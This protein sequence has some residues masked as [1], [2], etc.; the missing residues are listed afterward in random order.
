[1]GRFVLV[2]CTNVGR[3]IIQTFMNTSDIGAELVGVVNL[4]AEQAKHKANYDDYRDLIEKYRLPVYYCNHINDKETVAFI[5][6]LQPDIILQSGWSQKFS[7]EVLSLPRFACIGEHPAPLPKGRGAA[8]VNWA[9]LT[10][11]TQW[12]DS[13]FRMV[14]GYD[15][16]EIYA[17]EFFRIEP[18][19][20]V[21]TV[22][23][24]VARCAQK[25]VGR[26]A[27]RWGNGCFDVT[28]QDER[29]ATHYLRR[30]PADG[31][32]LDF[33]RPANVLHDF[34][35]AQTTPYPGAYVTTKKGKLYVLASRVCENMFTDEKPGNV[36]GVGQNGGLLM[37]CANGTVLELLRLQGEN[38]PSVWGADC[39][40]EKALLSDYAHILTV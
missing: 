9:I 15:K 12:G 23:E 2:A 33:D 19:D 28:V 10:G 17:Q 22:Y 20:T 27:A 16:G 34:I 7:N 11:E 35:R 37:A 31:E 40:K 39:W 36:F 1:M 29:Q 24:K 8:C 30:K 38:Q 6:G 5:K 18:Y 26:Y 32:I 25:V 21:F 13:Y 14:E 3:Y 4:N